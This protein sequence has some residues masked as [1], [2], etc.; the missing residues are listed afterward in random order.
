MTILRKD[1]ADTNL[2]SAT[3]PPQNLKQKET[4]QGGSLFLSFNYPG[5]PASAPGIVYSHNAHLTLSGV[6]AVLVVVQPANPTTSMAAMKSLTIAFIASSIRMAE[7]G[8]HG[9]VTSHP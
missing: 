7:F 1:S 4:H 2:S 3:A 8:R 6:D 9:T 5:P